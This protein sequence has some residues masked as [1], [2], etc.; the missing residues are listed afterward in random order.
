MTIL[1]R[2]VSR[3]QAQTSYLF[4][5]GHTTRTVNDNTV[6][7]SETKD[8]SIAPLCGFALYGG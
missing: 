2:A 8:R 7:A 5:V 3:T 6:V 4:D 1:T